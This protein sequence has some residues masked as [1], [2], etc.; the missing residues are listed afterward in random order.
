MSLYLSVV[1]ISRDSDVLGLGVQ[2]GISRF[3]VYGIEKESWVFVPGR[4]HLSLSNLVRGVLENHPLKNP[5]QKAA[6]IAFGCPSEF[7]SDI[8]LLEV[9][10]TL[11]IGH[12]DRHLVLT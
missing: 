2:T 5:K 7:D 3:V 4:K 6:G 8:L 9:A 12:G 10:N 1:I 11:V